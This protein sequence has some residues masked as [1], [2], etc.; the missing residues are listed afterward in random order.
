MQWITILAKEK[1]DRET[2]SDN[3]T[4]KCA[5]Y[6]PIT[7]SSIGLHSVSFRVPNNNH[8]PLVVVLSSTNCNKNNI[9]LMLLQALPTNDQS[10]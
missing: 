5:N 10:S 1:M 2:L 3:S 6:R 4:A 7:K 8:L 9:K